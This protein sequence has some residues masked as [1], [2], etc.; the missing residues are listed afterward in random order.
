MSS[1]EL[2]GVVPVKFESAGVGEGSVFFEPTSHAA[3]RERRIK[4]IEHAPR[5]WVFF[6]ITKRA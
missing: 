3:K 4:T 2:G 6:E 5:G 1:V